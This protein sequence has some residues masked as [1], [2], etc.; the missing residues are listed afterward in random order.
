VKE[1]GSVPVK[2]A[3][4]PPV[5]V[6]GAA[7]APPA[8]SEANE[9]SAGD[10]QPA[11][12]FLA[13]PRSP[14]ATP[15]PLTTTPP[16]TPK[17][18]PTAI[19]PTPPTPEVLTAAVTIQSRLRGALA[20]DLAVAEAEVAELSKG[21]VGVELQLHFL[22][23]QANQITARMAAAAGARDGAGGEGEEGVEVEAGA[24]I[25]GAMVGPEEGIEYEPFRGSRRSSAA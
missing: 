10:T 25:G 9:P 5:K 6:T 22:R 14:H 2:E 19:S 16:A 3:G 18:A 8:H 24:S 12:A 13:A 23:D 17:R 11:A 20:R 4:S 21:L 1:N 15:A 7:A